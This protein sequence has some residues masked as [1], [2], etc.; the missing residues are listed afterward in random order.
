M[1]KE[2]TLAVLCCKR[3]GQQVASTSKWARPPVHELEP[4]VAGGRAV[5]LGPVEVDAGNLAG[6][7]CLPYSR[8]ESDGPFLVGHLRVVDFI[9]GGPR[10]GVRFFDHDRVVT[11]RVVV[12]GGVPSQVVRAYGVRCS[13]KLSTR[14]Y[15]DMCHPCIALPKKGNCKSNEI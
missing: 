10:W 14:K 7:G 6:G 4:T 1:R 8:F 15:D 11:R 9:V 12:A 2:E 5:D 3:I 13:S